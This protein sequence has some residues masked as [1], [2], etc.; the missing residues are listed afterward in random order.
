MPEFLG[1]VFLEARANPVVS[2]TEVMAE[3]MERTVD[4][5]NEGLQIIWRSFQ[6][7]IWFRGHGV[8]WATAVW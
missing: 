4:V 1:V 5:V 6:W 8:G 2:N 7:K 3:Q